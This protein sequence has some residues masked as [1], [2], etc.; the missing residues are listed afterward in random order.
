MVSR[1][2]E[3]KG[4]VNV[5]TKGLVEPRI[6]PFTRM[7]QNSRARGPSEFPQGKIKGRLV[8]R[9]PGWRS[10]GRF[11]GAQAEVAH[12][13]RSYEKIMESPR[14]GRRGKTM[15]GEPRPQAVENFGTHGSPFHN[16]VDQ[17]PDMNKK[18]NKDPI[19][20]RI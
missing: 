19:R 10:R 18:E 9:K 3:R 13:R 2:W 16:R 17:G 14:A 7:V 4:V 8:S 12:Q 20:T 15:T 5:I 1:N 6:K 11:L